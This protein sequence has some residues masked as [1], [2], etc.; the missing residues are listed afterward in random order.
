MM[1][2]SNLEARLQ[3]ATDDYSRLQD[4]EHRS[5][6]YKW[7]G[8]NA[9]RVLDLSNVVSVRQNLEAQLNETTIVQQVSAF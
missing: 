8:S 5:Q 3:K 9:I 1:A 6:E 2:D 7:P 4:G